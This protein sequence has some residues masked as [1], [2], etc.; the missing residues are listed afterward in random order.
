MALTPLDVEKIEFPKK[1][2]GGYDPEAVH[3][4]LDEVVTTLEHMVKERDDLRDKI[5]RLTQEID[6]W[7]AKELLVTESVQ[8]AQKTRDQVIGSAQ[9]EAENIIKEAR[10]ESI[11]IRNEL[12]ALRAEKETFEFEFFGLL[13]GFLARLEQRNP[14]L[15]ASGRDA[16]GISARRNDSVPAENETS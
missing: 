2:F 7:R 10:F 5:A 4:F 16:S 12:S 1:T 9:T 6:G 14:S 11:H 3:D 13:M 15:V 8:L